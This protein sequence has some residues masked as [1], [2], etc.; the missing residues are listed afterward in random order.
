MRKAGFFFAAIFFGFVCASCVSSIGDPGMWDD[1]A[2]VAR[3]QSE[4]DKANA[5]IAELESRRQSAFAVVERADER[6]AEIARISTAEGTTL[7]AVIERQLRIEGLVA[8]LWGDYI[9]L[10][11]GLGEFDGS[12]AA[13]GGTLADGGPAE[14]RAGSGETAP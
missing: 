12:G 13:N 9:K 8:E 11:D 10:K 1:A 14:R 2:S 3:L 6:F 5:R 7:S 4:L